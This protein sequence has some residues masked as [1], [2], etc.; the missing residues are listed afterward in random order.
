ML[1]L[2]TDQLGSGSES[3]LLVNGAQRWGREQRTAPTNCC[4]PKDAARS[5]EILRSGK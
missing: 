1:L 4:C 3:L 2:F 5:L